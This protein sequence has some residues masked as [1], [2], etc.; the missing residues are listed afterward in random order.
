MRDM[1]LQMDEKELDAFEE[2]ID[3]GAFAPT[4]E[5]WKK[6]AIAYDLNYIAEFTDGTVEVPDE[7]KL[8]YAAIRKN[9]Y[10]ELHRKMRW[11]LACLITF[12]YIYVTA[13]IK[14]LYRMYKQQADLA[15]TYEELLSLLKN[16]PDRFNPCEIIGDKLVVKE[17]LEDEL[18]RK[19]EEH[20]SDMAYYIPTVDEILAYKENGYPACEKAYADLWGFYKNDLNFEADK[21]DQ[22]CVQAF[23][24]FISGRMPSHYIKI[25]ESEKIVF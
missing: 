21:C 7:V 5:E 9:G 23:Q 22:L 13:P 11:L 17:M 4:E 15:V 16:Q 12:S 20:Q 24:V 14:I 3:R 18:Y 8:V 2:A 1:L 19:I 25:V 6:L 10:R